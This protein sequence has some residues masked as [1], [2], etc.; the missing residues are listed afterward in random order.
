[1]LAQSLIE[2]KLWVSRLQVLDGAA[3]RETCPSEQRM[4]WLVRRVGRREELVGLAETLGLGEKEA[5]YASA[6]RRS[7]HAEKRNEAVPEKAVFQ[8][9]KTKNPTVR[10]RKQNAALHAPAAERKAARFVGL[11]VCVAFDQSRHVRIGGGSPANLR[12]R[13]HG[14]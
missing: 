5:R 12:R 13:W 2:D 9:E 7:S 10:F 8:D 14:A 6:A 4:C 1:M 11:G 3:P